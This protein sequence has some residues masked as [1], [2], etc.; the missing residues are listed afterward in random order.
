MGGLVGTSAVIKKRREKKRAKGFTTGPSSSFF[1]I[2]FVDFGGVRAGENEE[3]VGLLCLP[4]S[5]FLRA[6]YE[7]NN[8][9][10]VYNDI[11]VRGNTD[12]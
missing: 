7:E 4:P 3:W 1:F 6:G 8:F 12:M 10:M 5:P 11:T 9:C 2:N